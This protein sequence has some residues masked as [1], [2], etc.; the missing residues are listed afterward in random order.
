MLL[1]F[2]IKSV[3]NIVEDKVFL[4]FDT[5][6]IFFILNKLCRKRKKLRYFR[7]FL[8][9]LGVNPSDNGIMIGFW[10]NLP[11]GPYAHFKTF[12]SVCEAR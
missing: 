8:G 10:P 12:Y 11:P 1:L 6:K 2:K 9:N 4:F 3:V 5:R 7:E